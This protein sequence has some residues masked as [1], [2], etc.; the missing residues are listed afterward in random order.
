MTVRAAW[1]AKAKAYEWVG[2]G[3]RPEAPPRMWHCDRCP[4]GWRE[5]SPGDVTEE[6]C[7]KC[8]AGRMQEDP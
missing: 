6:Q 2:T 8:E 5:D 1:N 3:E 4:G 7:W